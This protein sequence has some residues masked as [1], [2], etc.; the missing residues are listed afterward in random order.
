MIFDIEDITAYGSKATPLGRDILV[1][2]PLPALGIV[3]SE[4]Y[5]K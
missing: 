4:R 3:D 5:R 2:T 1:K